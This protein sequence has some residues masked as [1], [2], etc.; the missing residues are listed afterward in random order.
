MTVLAFGCSVA[1]GTEIAAPGNSKDNIPYSYPSLVADHLGV[2]C[3]NRA[4]CGNSNENIFHEAISTI[5]NF[6][7]V[8]AVIIG[9]TSAEREVWRCDGRTWQFIPSWCGTTNDV[10]QSYSEIIP[11]SDS[12]PQRCA[13]KQEYIKVLDT[14]YDVLIKYKFD[15]EVYTK[16][17][18]N[19]ILALR[20][21]C[22]AN[23]I[24]LIETSWSDKIPGTV[25][26]G[27]IG[28]WYP[29]MQRHPNA[30][31]QQLFADQIITQYKL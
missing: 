14:I 1:H 4:F 25:D 10:W 3:V 29:A 22:S 6:T 28:T 15:P 17:R 24:K 19:Y 20:A 26:I 27:A 18:N 9:W 23:N 12:A 13:D 7:D 21:Y 8:T 5:P 2:A 30:E 11:R 31:E 16:K